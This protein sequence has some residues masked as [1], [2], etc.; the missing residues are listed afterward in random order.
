MFDKMMYR[1]FADFPYCMDQRGD[2]LKGGRNLDDHN[3]TIQAVKQRTVDFGITFNREKCEFGVDE[4]EIY[5]FRFM[6]DGVKPMTEKVKAVKG[7]QLPE[8]KEA[9]RSSIGMLGY[10]SKLIDKNSSLT[11]PLRKLTDRKETFK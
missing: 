10:L 11:A 5:G 7:S 9:V 2:I 3:K 1:I 8:T 4:I 6:K